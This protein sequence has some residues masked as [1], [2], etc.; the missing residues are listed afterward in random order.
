M[1]RMSHGGG[2]FLQWVRSSAF[3][4]VWFVLLLSVDVYNAGEKVVV[5]VWIYNER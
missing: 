2:A 4:S 5:I 1:L 3:L